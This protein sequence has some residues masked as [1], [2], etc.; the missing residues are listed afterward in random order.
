MRCWNCRN[1]IPEAAQAC[2]SCEAPVEPEPTE[3]EMDAVRG[4]LEQMPS[5]V[6]EELQAMAE[7]SETAEEFADRIL[8]GDCQ[9][10]GSLETGNCENDPQIRELL[11]GRCYQC[12]QLWCT[13]CL[14]LLEPDSPSCE[15]WAEGA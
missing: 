4:I 15:C 7:T 3:E 13:E 9:K 8:V 12:G 6:V 10:C 11:V 1:E 5:E 2:Q 14:R